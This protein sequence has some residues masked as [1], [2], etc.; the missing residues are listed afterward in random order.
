MKILNFLN[1]KLQNFIKMT[2][3]SRKLVQINPHKRIWY[4]YRTDKTTKK[5]RVS[6]N[7]YLENK[8]YK[9]CCCCQWRAPKDLWS[10]QQEISLI[11]NHY[12]YRLGDDEPM[13]LVVCHGR[14]HKRHDFLP[15]YEKA[16]FLDIDPHCWPDFVGNVNCID[17]AK[18]FPKEIFDEIYT[19]HMPMG[20]T[21]SNLA[22]WQ[23]FDHLLKPGGKVYLDGIIWQFSLRGPTAGKSYCW[24]DLENSIREH[25]CCCTFNHVEFKDVTFQEILEIYA[26]SWQGQMEYQSLWD[27]HVVATKGAKGVALPSTLAAKA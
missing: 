11:I 1:L 21:E 8:A 15:D 20:T 6:K 9:N 26:P 19:A 10:S 2:K 27:G 13:R 24:E 7:E 23:V 5:R 14:K 22:K 16:L 17:F 3:Y 4:Y 12:K 18:R 25:L